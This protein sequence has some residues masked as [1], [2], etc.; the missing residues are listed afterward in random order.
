MA[1]GS[2]PEN[3]IRADFPAAAT[4]SSR[5]T[6]SA[7]LRGQRRVAV[8][9]GAA[10]HQPVEIA[11]AGQVMQGHGGHQ[12]RGV[13]DAIDRPHALPVHDRRGPLV[14]ER[15][16]AAPTTARPAPSRGTGSRSCRPAR[17]RS[18]PA[19]TGHTAER[20]GDSRA[21]GAGS[22]VAKAPIV[23]TSTNDR[24]ANGTESRSNMN[25]RWK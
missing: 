23:P 22:G 9:P 17:P 21:R 25:R 18:C 6:N 11:L 5:P 19:G 8:R 14:K 1:R 24:I 13:G 10:A 12:K 7:S 3:G 16:Q 15:H 20:S 2:Q 4:S